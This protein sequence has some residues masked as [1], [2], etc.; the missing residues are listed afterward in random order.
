MSEQR[1]RTARASG[2]DSLDLRDFSLP[3]G[4]ESWGSMSD[5]GEFVPL[6]EDGPLNHAD[7]ILAM[8]T[9]EGYD[10]G[11]SDS[12]IYAKNHR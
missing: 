5:S 7:C 6:D 1:A 10:P 9:Q 11:Y 4:E 12:H 3:S 2:L 8:R